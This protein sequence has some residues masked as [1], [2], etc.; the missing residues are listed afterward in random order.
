MIVLWQE[1]HRGRQWMAPKQAAA[2]I[3]QPELGEMIK[4]LKP[5]LREELK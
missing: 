5:F 1:R 3:K 4:R 2:V